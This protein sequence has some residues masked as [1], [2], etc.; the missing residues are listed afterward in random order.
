MPGQ[1]LAFQMDGNLLSALTYEPDLTT[2]LEIREAAGAYTSRI[3]TIELENKTRAS[4]AQIDSSLFLAGQRA[5]LSDNLI[6]QLVSIFGWDIDFALDIRQGDRFHLVFEEHFR[7]STKVREGPI[8]AAEFV[9][10]GRVYRA[11][12]YVS[13]EGRVDYFNPE[14]A[15]MR[16]AFLRTPLKF[17]RIS[18]GFSLRRKH[19]VLNRIRAHRGVDYAA[20]HGTPIRATGD[21]RVLLAA[22]KGG[23]GKT[24]IL[25]HGGARSTLYAHMSRI[26][27]NIKK[28]AHVQQ[29]DILGYVGS[30]GLAT[31]P[32]LH[33]EFR[34]H[35]VHRNPLTVKLPQASSIPENRLAHFRQQTASL[36]AQLDRP[37]GIRM[38]GGQEVPGRRNTVIALE[39]SAPAGSQVY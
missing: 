2:V 17:S 39:D 29:G 36:L 13:P 24:V 8:L 25:R 9:N 28:G 1:E 5:G 22:R 23:Y 21:G 32:H 3:H 18:S 27:G 20:P 11:V 34:M 35:G 16:K 12:R 15:S 30:S 33:Y 19:P 10:Q 26:A 38:A 7:D 4:A 31:G 6:M 14:G 37:A